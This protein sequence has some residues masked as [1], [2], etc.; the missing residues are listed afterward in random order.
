MRLEQMRCALICK[1]YRKMQI[2]SSIATPTQVSPNPLAPTGYDE[3]PEDTA[4][5]LFKF[6][7]EGILN[8]AGG[9]CGTT[10]EHIHAI[11]AKAFCRG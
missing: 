11:G 6:A 9:C 8:M 2:V 1:P 7:E 4:N 3:K 10:P 5:F